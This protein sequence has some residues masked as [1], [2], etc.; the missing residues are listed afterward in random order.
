M[1]MD[2]T[3]ILNRNEYYTNHYFAS[4]FE[5]N[6]AD[7]IK[8]WREDAAAN[9][10]KTP[11]AQLKDVATRYYT[12]KDQASRS[13]GGHEAQ[14]TELADL[15]LRALGY[16]ELRRAQWLE[17]E[18]GAY[19]PVAL[20][21]T[22]PNRLPRLWVMLSH[23]AEDGGDILS[24]DVFMPEWGPNEGVPENTL[25]TD[26]E[27]MIGKVLFGQED[28]PRWVLLITLDQVALIDRNK[29]NEKRLLVF[30]LDNIFGRREETTLQAMAVLL[31][32]ESLCPDEGNSLLDVLDDNSHKHASGVSKDLKYALRQC[33]ELLGNEV[34]YDM[35][36]RQHVG[37]FGKDLAGELT[38]QCLRY[39]YRILFMLF[40]EAKPELGYA[41]MK[42]DTYAMG[43]SFESLREIA[44]AV[45]GNGEISE[46]GNYLK[47]SLDLLF[48]MVYDGFPKADMAEAH[49]EN[50]SGVF[51]IDPLKAH[52]FDPEKTALI[53]NAHLRNRVLL[54]IID[55]MS[56]TRARKGQRRGRISYANLGV[57]Q[58]GAVYEA[59]LS[60]RGFFAEEELY[61]VQRKGDTVDEL[62]VGYFVTARE[63]PQYDEDERVR[64]EDG[65]LRVHPKG[66]FIYR[67]AGRE[68]EKSA[69]YYTP[70][71]LT[72]CL[73]KY[74]L[75]E[76][77]EGKSADDILQLAICEPAMGSA[78]FLNEAVSQLAEAY[79][80]RKE[81]ERGETVPSEDRVQELQKVKMF[82]ADR[83]VYGIDLNPTAVELAEVSLWLNTIYQGGYVPWFR[84]QIVNGNSLIGA[85][86]QCY[87]LNQTQ[88]KHLWYESA[89]ERI[90]PGQKRS[91]RKGHVYHF[92]LGDP[93]MCAYTDK[94]IKQMEPEKLAAIKNWNKA[95]TRELRD[96]EQDDLLRLSNHIDTLWDAHAQMRR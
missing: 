66:E 8:A 79:L 76:L 54:Q 34:I 40:I 95:F 88:G 22:K 12:L 4:I 32:K 78:A 29:W 49:S 81:K 82:I 27:T 21:L 38:L 33:I 64:N 18:K 61:E 10:V 63:L 89:P 58:L 1:A 57:N 45:R 14:I 53:E 93:G 23:E 24:G 70:E 74:A 46:D 39:M 17:T 15:L 13:R 16:G 28:P 52:I 56:L 35:R 87:P 69:S 3:G 30:D 71:V 94:V 31:S 55:L 41:P 80:S 6:A 65:S 19:V 75:K 86:R 68:R 2:L 9:N 92:L 50:L 44:D 42:A 83:N 85:R 26:N 59:L 84:T 73:V 47:E 60:Y 67:L 11:W 43:Y 51:A 77:L 5:E 37:V 62:D 90:E 96:D 36:E 20:E 91:L 48:R 7:T 25:V 72:K